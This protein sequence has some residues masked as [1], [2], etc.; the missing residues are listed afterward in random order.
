MQRDAAIDAHFAGA[1]AAGD[2][3]SHCEDCGEPIP[4]AR[5]RIVPGCT[6]C[7]PCQQWRN[8]EQAAYPAR[9]AGGRVA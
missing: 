1:R 7:V 6:R 5:Q 2:S 9:R 8:D 3:L 4:T